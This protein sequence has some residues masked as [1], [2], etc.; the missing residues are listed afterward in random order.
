MKIVETNLISIKTLKG[1]RMYYDVDNKEVLIEKDGIFFS[2]KKNEIFPVVR[3]MVS[4]IQ[5]FYR[6]H[7][8][9]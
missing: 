3:G 7:I 6:K 4:A 1:L 2:I 5:R 8:K 9:R